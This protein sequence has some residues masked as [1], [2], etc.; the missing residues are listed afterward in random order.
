MGKYSYVT[1]GR[2]RSFGLDL[3]FSPTSAPNLENKKSWRE[4]TSRQPLNF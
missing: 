1:F 2:G 4:T 3:F